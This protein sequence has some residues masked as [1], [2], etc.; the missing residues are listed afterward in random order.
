MPRDPIF[1]VSLGD[2]VVLPDGRGLTARCRVNLPGTVG[3]MAGFIICGEM[4]ALL[5]LPPTSSGPVNIYVPVAHFPGSPDQART[6]YEGAA[7]YWAP[8]LPS[9]TGAMAEVLY[10]VVEIRGSVDPVVAVYRG[11]EVI[12]FIRATFASSGE[13][14]VMHMP[15][16]NAND[17][18]VVRHAG[19]V[20]APVPASEPAPRPLPA[21]ARKRER[22]RVGT[23]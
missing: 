1:D 20:D 4:E 11:A 16:S 12:F 2:I 3:S 7:S 21:P 5:S 22:R 8:H 9:I 19:V 13:I 14:K 10:R 23:H 18:D 17:Y 6:V 15:R